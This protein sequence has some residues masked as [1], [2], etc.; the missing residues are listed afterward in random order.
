M[1]LRLLF[2]FMIVFQFPGHARATDLGV[3]GVPI[4]LGK[5]RNYDSIFSGLKSAGITV[6]FPTSQYLEQP[7]AKSLGTETD[8]LAPCTPDSPAFK[9]LRR[10]G[11]RLIV[12]GEL[13]YLRGKRLPPL[14]QDPLK[15][16]IEC[17]GR[18]HIYGVL[19]YDEPVLSGASLE[20]V[21]ALYE[22][23]KAID[24]SLPVLMVHAPMIVDMPQFANPE[25][26][27]DYLD[28]VKSF[29]RHAD[30]VGFD[31]YPVVKEINKVGSPSSKGEIVDHVTAIKD[32]TRW[33][34][35]SVPGQRYFMVLQGFSL[36]DQFEPELLRTMAPDSILD[37]IR[38]PNLSETQEMAQLSIDG[39]A[40]L[41]VWW[42]VS[43]QKND[44]SPIWRNILK[45]A[46][47]ISGAP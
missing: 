33:L 46:R 11:L 1:L 21:A 35:T 4:T 42:G 14:A 13:L 29:S 43:F 30:V 26:Q 18:E 41:L 40:D 3:A 37:L 7:E 2:V 6:Y 12:A 5:S 45:T 38:A 39:G 34:R 44:K 23:V 47:T 24:A 28:Q 17:A 8:F 32:Y 19:T 10:H 16:I 31:V 9:A 22:R 27:K 36:S 20:S 25:G 15:D